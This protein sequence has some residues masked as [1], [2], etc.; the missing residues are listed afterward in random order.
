MSDSVQDQLTDEALIDL[1]RST[2]PHAD[3]EER[4]VAFARAALSAALSGTTT[5]VS[6]EN[7]EQPTDE[8]VEKV[9]RAIREALDDVG[10]TGEAA[11]RAARAALSGTTTEWG[12]LWSAAT[13][14][15]PERCVSREVAIHASERWEIPLVSREVTEWHEVKA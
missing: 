12:V 14:P 10:L 3:W 15:R 6:R 13:L 7:Q 4:A 9:A 11:T 8:A 5:E 1:W 2:R